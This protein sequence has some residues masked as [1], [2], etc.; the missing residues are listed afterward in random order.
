LS[1]LL[2]IYFTGKPK[3][4]LNDVEIMDQFSHKS[5]AMIFYIHANNNK[6]NREQ[7][8]N[9]LWENS[10]EKAARYNLRYNIWTINKLYSNLASGHKLIISNK[11][12][13]SLNPKLIIE[14][15]IEF[16]KELDSKNDTIINDEKLM[17]TKNKCKGNFMESFY[18]KNCNAFNDWMFYERENFQKKYNY[19]LHSLK[20]SYI[21]NKQYT[22]AAEILDEM[23]KL[24]PYDEKLYSDLIQVLIWKG[25]R[26]QA[27]KEYNRCTN[28]LREELNI[29]PLESTKKLIDMIKSTDVQ[30]NMK[31]EY[32]EQTI[33]FKF[34]CSKT[35]KIQYGFIS[36]LI[37]KLMSDSQLFSY[38]QPQINQ[39]EGLH[40]LQPIVF[41]NKISRR[42]WMSTEIYDNYIFQLTI[43]LIMKMSEYK[44]IHLIIDNSIDMDDKSQQF[45][46]LLLHHTNSNYGNISIT[47]NN[48][49]FKLINDIESDNFTIK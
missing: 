11:N 43:A 2:T 29:A 49:Y 17:L 33:E 40:Y 32:L 30:R 3:L 12:Y 34:K 36:E 4:L 26:I 18:L 48:Q 16:L 7:V 8:S 19:V 6:I 31:I 35:F 44:N 37:Q 38:I 24:N 20:D 27:L 28:V 45:I 10:D 47:F 14:T 5:L 23:I 25:D 15:D 1:D 39:F 42:E 13:L 22:L 46:V 9:L 21:G 41:K